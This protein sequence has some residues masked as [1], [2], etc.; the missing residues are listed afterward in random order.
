M[1]QA[2][3]LSCRGRVAVGT[4]AGAPCRSAAAFAPC[5]DTKIISRLNPCLARTAHHVAPA[6]DRV[7]ALY[8]SLVAPYCDTMIA[9]QPRYNFCIATSPPARSCARAAARPC[10]QAGRIVALPGRVA[11]PPDRV[12]ATLLHAPAMPVTIQNIVS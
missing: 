4:R 11:G 9:P 2:M 1:S 10:S 7:T 8:R 5:H 3:P 12:V 6:L